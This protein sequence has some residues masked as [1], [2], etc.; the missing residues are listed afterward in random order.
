M[1]ISMDKRVSKIFLKLLFFVYVSIL[2]Y[3]SLNPNPPF[4]YNRFL[5]E[6][7][8]WHF[9]VYMVGSIILYFSFF[10]NARKISRIVY[11]LFFCFFLIFPV[12]DEFYQERLPHRDGNFFDAFFS[13]IGFLAGFILSVISSTAID[14]IYR[15]DI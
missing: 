8:L 6:D 2:I 3:F 14:G 1:N 9:F 4:N 12:L 5:N 15:K 7:K 13:I 11:F 10:K